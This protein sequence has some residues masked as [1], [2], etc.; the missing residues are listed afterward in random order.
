[1]VIT[2]DNP[3]T[4]GNDT[5]RCLNSGVLQLAGAPADGT[6]SGLHV[7]AAGAFDPVQEGSFTLTYSVG[8]GSCVTQDQVEVTVHPLP[9]IDLTGVANACVD[10][11]PQIFTATPPGG[12]GS[13]TGITDAAAGSFDPALAGAGGYPIPYA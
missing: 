11:G 7:D 5:A 8:S 2:I 6:W 9:A 13:G 10:G 3:A 1:T 4:A 12:T